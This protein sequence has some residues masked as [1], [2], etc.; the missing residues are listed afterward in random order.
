MFCPS[1]GTQYADGA[2]FCPNCG[3]PAPGA[4][5]PGAPQ[6]QP[7]QPSSGAAPP[8]APRAGLSQPQLL[9]G[10]GIIA[11]I[12]AALV[13]VFVVLGGD[14]D[15]GGSG[16]RLDPARANEL[17]AAAIIGV[18]DL[19]G[20][21]WEL[22]EVDEFDEDEDEVELGD[23]ATCDAL[24][25]KVVPTQRRLIANRAGRAQRAY[26]IETTFSE[27]DL[28]VGIEVVVYRDGT[29]ISEA[30][31]AYRSVLGSNDFIRCLDEGIKESFDDASV[32]GLTPRQKAPAGGIAVAFDFDVP[33]LPFASGRNEA[34]FWRFA[35]GVVIV[36]FEG[37]D[38]R[39]TAAL[40][41]EVLTK[42]EARVVQ[43][44]SANPPPTEPLAR[45]S[46]TATPRPATPR[47]GAPTTTTPSSGAFTRLQD[48]NSYKYTLR[49]ESTGLPE[50]ANAFAGVAGSGENILLEASGS[51]VKPDRS[52][53]TWK[54]GTLTIGV[55]TIGRQQWLSLGGATY[56]A[57]TTAARDTSDYS[58]AAT[59]WDESL[60]DS[61]TN[62]GCTSTIETVNGVRARRCSIDSPLLTEGILRAL[63]GTGASSLGQTTTSRINTWIAEQ[64]GYL[65]RLALDVVGRRTTGQSFSL[66]IEINVTDVNTPITINPPR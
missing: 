65:V 51:Y 52:Q 2:R 57:P 9:I 62:L 28:K 13:I 33:D 40:V 10:G 4:P 38:A 37:S 29:G 39:V 25:A 14:G 50:I 21:G 36:S 11:A 27:P 1:C 58:L 32:K 41:S 26:V 53:Q 7:Q 16:V 56:A 34:Y 64:G 5:P 15:G 19:P 45:T 35:N 48:L 20:R 31:S 23:T 55:V 22:S 3:A 46:P 63:S 60:I 18:N 12:A 42:M 17:A 43:A 30:F 59:F 47:P 6:A 61:A 8:G 24:E 44:G 49:L 66:K 54:L